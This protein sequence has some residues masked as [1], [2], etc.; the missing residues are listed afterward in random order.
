M[1]GSNEAHYKDDFV[2]LVCLTESSAYFRYIGS[3]PL[4]NQQAN[5]LLLAVGKQTDVDEK[6]KETPTQENKCQEKKNLYIYTEGKL[7]KRK[8]KKEIIEN[9][10]MPLSPPSVASNGPSRWPG[11]SD[12]DQR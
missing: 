4:S 12:K 9:W 10:S 8:G 2:A 5:R 6:G 3:C 1:R 7:T 11:Q